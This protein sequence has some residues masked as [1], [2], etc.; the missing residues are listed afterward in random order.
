MKPRTGPVDQSAK[1]QLK[2]LVQELK[3]P[4]ESVAELYI[5]ALGLLK[6]NEILLSTID[7][8]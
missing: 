5:R 8:Q 4:G 2:Y 7:K 3:R 1:H 6:M